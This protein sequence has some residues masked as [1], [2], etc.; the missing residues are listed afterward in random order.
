MTDIPL[1]SA[2]LGQLADNLARDP[3]DLS[4]RFG[5]AGALA[6]AGRFDEAIDCL[7]AG[8]RYHPGN[9][10]LALEL[11]QLLSHQHRHDDA[12]AVLQAG[13]RARPDH[14]ALRGLLAAELA[15]GLAIPA[16]IGHVRLML[17]LMPDQPLLYGNYA[18]LLQSAGQAAASLA[19]YD[20]SLQLDSDN[21]IT[22][23][24]LAT[25]LMTIGDFAGG[26]RH[27]EHRL[28][29]TDMRR[30]PAGLPLWRGED[31]A[32]KAILVTAEQGFGDL[33]QFARFLAPLSRRARQLWFECPVEMHRLFQTL[34]GL[35][36]VLGPGDQL[37][38]I[39]LAV[40]LLSLPF[41]LGQGND[42]LSGLVPYLTPPSEGPV[43]A[44][45]HRSKIGLIWRGRPAKGDLFIRRSLDRRSCSLSELEPLW[46]LD[47]FKWFGLQPDATGPEITG[48]SLT[49]LS[50]A[51]RDFADSASLMAQLDLVISI[52]TAGAHLAAALGCPLW[53]LLA[54]GQSDYRWNGTKGRS[55]WYPAARLWRA[56]DRGWSDVARLMAAR[57]TQIS[58]AD[59]V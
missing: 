16:A 6:T 23:V 24:N 26:F 54:P 21:A 41:M 34:P 40:P 11:G 46:R 57:L 18:V 52:D 38:P 51:I 7:A 32:G 10:E 19:V 4:R 5:Y 37:P 58:W 43:L 35:T 39:D 14:L 29:L 27:Y 30:P 36:G 12:Q 31:L 15:A 9:P 3:A 59:A 22:H 17:A 13:L 33:V 55:P 53:M 20:R 25:A 2:T 8:A 1:H 48:T 28:R 49:D 50:P 47:Q 56:D 44:A 42:L 45:D